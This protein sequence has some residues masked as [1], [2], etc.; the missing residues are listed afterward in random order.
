[1]MLTTHPNSVAQK[2]DLHVGGLGSTA[3]GA[4]A[5]VADPMMDAADSWVDRVR[6]AVN[7]ADDYVHNNPW[8]ALA[9]VAVLGVAAGYLLSR[10]S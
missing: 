9:V 8:A 6:G 1:M 7:D 5:A 10:R 2:R 3:A 4:L